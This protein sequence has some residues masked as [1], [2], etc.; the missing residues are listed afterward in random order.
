MAKTSR[1]SGP[2]VL[3]AGLADRRRQSRGLVGS[4][5]AGARSLSG[6]FGSNGS[7]GTPEFLERAGEVLSA[8]A[9]ALAVVARLRSE[10]NGGG[11]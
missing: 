11:E 10:A 3:V 8:A 1:V 5:A 6:R 7:G 9:V 4:V 2:M